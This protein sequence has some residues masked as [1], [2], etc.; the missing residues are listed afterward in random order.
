MVRSALPESPE[1]E[2][3]EP[4]EPQQESKALRLAR[5]LKEFVGLRSTTIRDVDKYES[6][7]WF[8]D[9]PQVTDCQS[10]AWNDTFEPG[11]PWLVVRKQR[12]PKPPDPPEMILPWIDQQALRRATPEMPQLRQSIFLP[13][14]TAE[15]GPDEDPPLIERLLTE[16]P[17][18]S[19]AYKRYRPGWEAWSAEY[20]R[21]EAVRRSRFFG[22]SDKLK[23]TD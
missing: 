2:V 19:G 12:F 17:E 8:A 1:Q 5:Y 14:V 20:R 7:L 15:V 10:A 13:D 4:L 23:L 11:E 22:Q 18:V 16:H 9:M 21:R 3:K 6:V